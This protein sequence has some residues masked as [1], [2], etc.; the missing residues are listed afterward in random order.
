MCNT[1]NIYSVFY[2]RGSI[3]GMIPEYVL[4]VTC[5]AVACGIITH[6]IDNKSPSS[7]VTKLVLG[8]V[9]TVT[10]LKPIMEVGNI[11]YDAYFDTLER[12]RSE[13]LADANAVAESMHGE[14]ITEKIQS[15]ILSKAETLDLNLE[16]DVCLQDNMLPQKVML[17]GSVSPYGKKQMEHF[18]CTQLGIQKECVSWS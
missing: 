7:A 14:I 15:Y 5:T 12:D 3:M 6:F 1:D 9:M 8:I 11:S 2:E 13:I 10:I 4:S 17:S 16:V 18:I